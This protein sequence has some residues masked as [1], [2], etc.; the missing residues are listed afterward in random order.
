MITQRGIENHHIDRYVVAPERSVIMRSRSSARLSTQRAT[1]PSLHHN[2]VLTGVTPASTDG[3]QPF[4]PVPYTAREVR[5]PN[6]LREWTAEACS[7][8]T[9]LPEQPTC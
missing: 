1:D 5:P 3:E 9:E 4:K 6:T 7:P 2:D 8:Y